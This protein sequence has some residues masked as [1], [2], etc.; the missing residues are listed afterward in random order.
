MQHI[1]SNC[2]LKFQL[3]FISICFI[4]NNSQNQ[5]IRQNVKP[6]KSVID[7]WPVHEGLIDAFVE[8]VKAG[9]NQIPEADRHKAVILYSAHSLPLSAVERGDPYPHE[10]IGF[11][12]K[13]FLS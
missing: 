4:E 7:R 1:V 9:L 8:C 12:E 5:D 10:G 2:S 11:R 13:R 6:L 3:H